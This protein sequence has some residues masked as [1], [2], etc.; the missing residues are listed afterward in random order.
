MTYRN[1]KIQS[2]VLTLLSKSYFAGITVAEARDALPDLH[3]GTISGALS[4][5][6]KSETIARLS[7]KRN[8]CK[9]Y[10]LP[11]YVGWRP[12]ERQGRH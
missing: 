8:G 5:L 12:T 10:V 1:A 3:H 4:V 2:R 9:I 7:D 11:G 6:H